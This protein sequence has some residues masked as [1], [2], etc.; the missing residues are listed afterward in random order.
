MQR[1]PIV[2]VCYSD[3]AGQTRGKGFPAS[4]LP[5][6]LRKGVGWTPT[7]IMLT[8]FGPIADTPWGPFGDLVLMPDPATEVRLDF[9]DEH[10]REHFF[11][12]DVLHTGGTPWDCC[13][14]TFL[15]RALDD[16][17][18]EAGLRLLSAFEH[19]FHYEGAD[20]RLGSAY[21]LDALRRHGL[22]GEVF[23]AALRAAGAEPDSYLAEYGPR[24]YEVTV[25][26]AQGVT[27]ADRAVIL[28]EVARATARA[29]GGHRLS[30]AP[31]V[32]PEVVGNGVHI[33]MSLL[34]LEGRPV[35]H[36][37]SGPHG[38]SETAGRFAAGVL[39]HARSLCALTAP[40]VVSYYRLVPHRWSAAWTNLG[41]RDREACVRICPVSEVPGAHV[42]AQFNIEFRAADAAASPYLALGALVRAGL[43][44]LRRGLPV[45]EPTAIDPETLSDDERARRGIVRLPQSL[46]EAL[47]ALAGDP[48]AKAWFPE[49]LFDA[50]LRHKRFEAG[51][52]A[53]LD[54]GAR[55]ARYSQAY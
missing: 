55:C 2:M 14:R 16:L 30:F 13:P 19:E 38:L 10:P 28:R 53:E 42:A 33:H 21:N 36:D 52:M 43:E 29:L 47:D 39:H 17:E 11:L 23:I 32:T 50:Y 12:A 7:N 18:R 49:A 45:P 54:R 48:A 44:G 4:D 27:A 3:I 6:R 35:T 9:G 25:A 20:E 46:D 37:P 31:A 51:L 22:F 15:K 41:H 26:P 1:E 24:Q 40:S 34:D 5:K 8:A